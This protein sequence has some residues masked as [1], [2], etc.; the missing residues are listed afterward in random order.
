[1]F[2]DIGLKLLFPVIGFQLELELEFELEFQGTNQEVALFVLDASLLF[3]LEV[4]WLWLSTSLLVSQ[5]IQGR[6]I[7]L[8]DKKT[9][10]LNDDINKFFIVPDVYLFLS[11]K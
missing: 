3:W 10:M 8:L 9:K 5:G 1:L 2:P 6:A 4:F 11:I 7:A